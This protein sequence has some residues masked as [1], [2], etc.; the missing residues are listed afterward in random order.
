MTTWFTSDHHFGHKNIIEYCRRPYKYVEEM[1]EDLI[2]RWNGKVGSSDIVYH[3][4]DFCLG[5]PEKAWGYFERLNGRI[6]VMPGN[7]D[8]RW[9]RYF[10]LPH[11]VTDTAVTIEQPIHSIDIPPGILGSHSLP[12]VMCHYPMRSWDRSHYGAIHLFGHVHNLFDYLSGTSDD[13][14]IPPGEKRG[15]SINVCVEMWDY[16]P[17]SMEEI[18]DLAKSW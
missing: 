13:K 7:H 16:Y 4:G 18:I 9:M 3:L 14:V 11:E 6:H 1:D 12:I 10:L 17:V 5:G 15:V 2:A 8:H